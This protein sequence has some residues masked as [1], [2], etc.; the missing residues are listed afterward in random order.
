MARKTDELAVSGRIR[1]TLANAAESLSIED[2]AV[3][4]TLIAPDIPQVLE[5]LAQL[6]TGTYETVQTY[7][8][9]AGKV[10]KRKSRQAPS[11][12]AATLL[13]AYVYGPPPKE[14]RITDARS[15]GQRYLDAILEER[16]EDAEFT[17]GNGSADDD[18]P[19]PE[20]QQESE[21]EVERD[22]NPNE[23]TEHGG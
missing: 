20:V 5:T 7:R 19:L 22:E 16:I 9:A 13:L 14:V 15:P 18:L 3:L 10:S 11:V 6:A 12:P 1:E 21:S 23:G 4:A 2:P 17:T 8:T